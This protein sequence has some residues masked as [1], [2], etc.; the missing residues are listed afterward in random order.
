MGKKSRLRA[1]R[2]LMKPNPEY[3]VRRLA[4]GILRPLAVE[5]LDLE[6]EIDMDLPSREPRIILTRKATVR[7]VRP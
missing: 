2:N 4:D 7:I 6:I 1:L 3:E 5:N